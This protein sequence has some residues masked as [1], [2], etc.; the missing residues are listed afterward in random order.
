V[1]VSRAMA[2]KDDVSGDL[3]I[4]TQDALPI[5]CQRVLTGKSDV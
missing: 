3:L 5:C 2:C 1:E 4:M